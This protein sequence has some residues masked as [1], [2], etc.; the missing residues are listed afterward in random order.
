M[1][2]LNLYG[3]L[4]VTHAFVGGMVESGWGRVV[5]IISDA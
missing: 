2:R 5:T 3:V 1:I 4:Y